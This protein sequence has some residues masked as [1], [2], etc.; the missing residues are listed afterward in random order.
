MLLAAFNSAKADIVADYGWPP[1]G[2]AAY[3]V[4]GTDPANPGGI[5]VSYTGFNSSA[6]GQL[7]FGL[8]YIDMGQIG[9]YNLSNLTT[10]GS[11]GGAT[12]TW[13]G[14]VTINTLGGPR[15]TTGVF[16]ATLNNGMTWIDPSTVGIGGLNAPLT[17]ANVS[18]DFAVTETFT[19]SGGAAYNTWYNGFDTLNLQSWTDSSGDFWATPA[20]VRTDP[21]PSPIAGAGLP[22]LIFAGGGL[23]GWRRRKRKLAVAA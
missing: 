13:S 18:G 2:G 12:Q 19:V 3:A 6:Y 14:T 7:Y 20:A 23:L 15:T 17:V 4:T 21:V 5:N 22:G 8:D 9:P 1:P 11:F 10:I 16:T